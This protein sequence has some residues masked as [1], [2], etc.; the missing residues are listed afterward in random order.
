MKHILIALA[1]LT[2][3]I[4]AAGTVTLGTDPCGI[5]K[6]CIDIP[7]DAGDT[8]SLYGAPGYP[9]FF[10]YIDGVQYKATVPSGMGVDS[11]VL[12]DANGDVAYLTASFSTYRTCTHSGRG[13]TCSTHW[14][15]IGGTLVR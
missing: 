12:T 13:Q 10:L 1:L 5:V 15:L 4:A 14:S 6:Q 7:N 3:D 11:A 2:A 8:I 9:Y